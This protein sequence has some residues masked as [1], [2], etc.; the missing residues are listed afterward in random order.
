MVLVSSYEG[1]AIW[2]ERILQ[3]YE[4][5]LGAP[6]EQIE[7]FEVYACLRRLFSIVASIQGGAEKLGMDSSA[8]AIMKEQMF[9]HRR[10][11]EILLE[12]T[13]VHVPEVEEMLTMFS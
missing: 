5:V 9:A 11:Y 4:Q 1:D 3:T 6:V 2:R 13:G 7:Y 12:K 8:V 10:V